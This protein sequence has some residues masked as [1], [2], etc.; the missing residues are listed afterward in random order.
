MRV[1]I[2][3]VMA[4]VL[5]VVFGSGC[6]KKE[7]TVVPGDKT[8]TVEVNTDQGKATVDEGKKSITEEELGVPVYPGAVVESNDKETGITLTSTDSFDKVSKFYKDNLKN[9]QK[10]MPQDLNGKKMIM[11]GLLGADGSKI[12]VVVV[13]MLEKKVT[14]ITVMKMAKP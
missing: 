14:S 5:A 9:I 10:T 6:A 8:K 4:L 3:V 13:D 7:A 2:L 1:R 11:F 12:S